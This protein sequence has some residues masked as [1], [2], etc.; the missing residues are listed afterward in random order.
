[1]SKISLHLLKESLEIVTDKSKKLSQAIAKRGEDFRI[2]LLPN[3]MLL[4]LHGHRWTRFD[5]EKISEE[6]VEKIKSDILK[7]VH[8]ADGHDEQKEPT[9]IDEVRKE[10]AKRLEMFIEEM[11]RIHGDRVTVINTENS[12]YQKVD[13]QHPGE[14]SIYCDESGK[15]FQFTRSERNNIKGRNFITGAN[16]PVSI[17]NSLSGRGHWL[18]KEVKS[19]ERL[20]L[21]EL[22]V[23]FVT[24]SA[25]MTALVDDHFSLPCYV[26]HETT[27][28]IWSYYNFCETRDSDSDFD[29]IN[30]SEK[31]YRKRKSIRNSMR[32]LDNA[33]IMYIVDEKGKSTLNNYQNLGDDLTGDF[34]ADHEDEDNEDEDNEDE[35]NED[36]DN[37]D[38]E[39]DDEDG[40]S[41]STNPTPEDAMRSLNALRD[42]LV[43]QGTSIN[44]FCDQINGRVDIGR[45]RSL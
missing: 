44:R 25:E 45:R 43:N 2:D 40:T 14:I 38:D 18:I 17:S 4:H 42:I 9:F 22:C 37:E 21:E 19:R 31:Y 33:H 5:G 10:N 34:S 23:D 24:P 8:R 30:E 11:K 39:D 29:Q 7:V 15:I 26:E 27:R 35:D 28:G 16:I 20:T 41:P 12:D 36:E 32:G 3:D 6:T 13:E 1:M